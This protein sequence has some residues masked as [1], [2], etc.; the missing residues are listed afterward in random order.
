M[1]TPLAVTSRITKLSFL[2]VVDG[3]EF[4]PLIG[5]FRYIVSCTHFDLCFAINFLY[6]FMHA[7]TTSH[8]KSLKRCIR[9]LQHN[10]HHGILYKCTPHRLISIDILGWSDSDGGGGL[11]C[12]RSTA[13]FVF[14]L[15]GGAVSWQSK[16]QSTV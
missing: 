4:R 6:R 9:Y 14:T 13:A 7:P 3:T 16:K 1:L 2:S 8:W 10:K 11:D 12:G 15:A 5:E